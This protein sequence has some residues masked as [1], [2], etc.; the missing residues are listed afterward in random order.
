MASAALGRSSEYQEG[1]APANDP[2]RPEEPAWKPGWLLVVVGVSFV[3]LYTSLFSL[4]GIPHLRNGDEAFF[5]TY[6][7]R[8]LS[9]QV[10]LRDFH[11]FTPPGADLVYA[12]VF[13][14]FGASL[15]SIDWT[16]AGLGV[17]VGL[18]CFICAR[19][20]MREETAALAALGC[21]VVLYGDRMDATHHWFSSLANLLAVLAL[22]RGG[23]WRRVAA[24]AS[25]IAVA[26]FF[27][28]TAGVVGL[29]AC[30]AGLWWEMRS[31]RL[32]SRAW[33][34]RTAA[35]AGI[36]VAVWLMLSGRFMVQAGIGT[37]WFE[38]V[39]YLPRDSNFPAGF[40]VPHFSAEWHVRSLIALAD[41]LLVY[42][43]LLAVCPYVAVLCLRR[44]TD[45]QE[46][47]T[48]LVLLAS[49]GIFQTLEVITVLN[50][51]RMA[52]AAMPAVI[53]GVWLMA[54]MGSKG[55]RMIIASW[56]VV[57]AMIVVQS[58]AT[59]ARRYPLLKL[60][61]GD[62]LLE[63]DDVEEVA[64]LVA[65]TRPEDCF[66]E[67]ANTRLYVPLALRDPVPV[68]L[69]SAT[70]STLPQWVSESVAG[71]RQCA[72]RYILWEPHAGLGPVEQRSRSSNDHLDPLRAY[73]REQ[74]ARGAVFS[75]GDEI[76]ER[77][78]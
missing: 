41:H 6:A 38:Q 39:A 42:L 47:S 40:L 73:M 49:L 67:V 63:K 30:G 78:Y 74:Y 33:I 46:N 45:S 20:V 32:S 50:W 77:K 18:V 25:M 35:L 26:A 48:A 72:T 51:N 54:R 7:S 28:Q 65:H 13:R 16:I 68:V 21:V 15:R 1:S 75:N 4:T 53:L 56:C 5:W 55:R 71:L 29:L 69:L 14:V 11:Q 36:A 27:T 59:Q 3:F 2:R 60:P 58:G 23:A 19:R 62:A 24:A 57:G 61:A 70:E 37:Y 10:F 52:A 31:G 64:W 9:G 22:M 8:L 44:R 34:A 17:A 66:F 43:L 76:W 12:A